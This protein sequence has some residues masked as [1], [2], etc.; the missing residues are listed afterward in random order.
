MTRNV[1]NRTVWTGDN[2]DILRG[3]NSRTVD[4]IYLDPPFNS[5]RRYAAPI[6]SEAAGAAFKDSWTLQD[7]DEAWHGEV[8]DREPALYTSI[9]A[10]GITNGSAM[11]AYLIMMAVRLLELRRVLRPEGSVYLHCDPTA[12][13][14]L[15]LVMDAIFGH[16]NFR[17]E[18]VWRR[19]VAHNDPKR[20]GNNTDRLLYYTRGP[21]G[22]Q[23][24]LD[25]MTAAVGFPSSRKGRITWNGKDV[26]T[27]KTDEELARAYPQQDHRGRFRA[28]NLTGPLHAPPSGRGESTK[29]W[30]GY[31]VA[32]MGRCW[33]APLT[34]RYA[35]WIDRNIIPGYRSIQ[36][37]HDRLNALDKAGMIRHPVS[38]KWP[39]LKRYAEADTG[40]PLQSLFVDISGF[41]NF[42]KGKEWCGYPTQ[43]PLALLERIIRVSSNPGD[44]VLDPFCGCATTMVAAETLGREWVGIDL[45]PL[46]VRLVEKRLR[47]EHGFFG[48]IAVREDVP[49]RTDQ[50]KLP[51]YR[52]HRHTLFG[53]QEGICTGCLT[54][55]PF[56]NFTVDHV[57][58]K[59]KGGTDHIDNLQLLCGAC[60]SLKG[61]GTMEQLIARLVTDGIRDAT[62]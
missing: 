8:A 26:A 48:E 38:G 56:R 11:K 33:S 21:E 5:N 39:G 57:V 37:V 7:V 46:A 43:K 13:H 20:Y 22:G 4:L 17:N 58:P 15:K 54:A 40:N 55:F 19:S 28:D 53:R 31:D 9:D 49:M 23:L 3:I 2:L 10:A 51:D 60:N 47:D 18:I 12:S 42:N 32:G 24:G 6:G 36:G 50:G 44:L 27:P 41:T 16:R 1:A 25:G 62:R 59:S 29:P 14:Y 52:T 35:E 45:S 30:K 61:R 34:G